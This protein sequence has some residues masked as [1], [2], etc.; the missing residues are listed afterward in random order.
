MIFKTFSRLGFRPTQTMDDRISCAQADDY[1]ERFVKKIRKKRENEDED[2]KALIIYIKTH[3][4]Q[5]K[6]PTRTF[7]AFFD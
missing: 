5:G 1:M 7:Y 3:G 2:L 6:A 4:S